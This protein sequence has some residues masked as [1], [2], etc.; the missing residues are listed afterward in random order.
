MNGENDDGERYRCGGK[1]RKERKK[2]ERKRE[3]KGANV[4]VLVVSLFFLEI[5]KKN[6]PVCPKMKLSGRKMAPKGPERTESMVPGSVL[7]CFG[8][9]FF[10]FVVVEVRE[11]KT[12][13]R[14]R[15]LD[16]V[17]CGVFFPSSSSSF[18]NRCFFSFSLR[19]RR[20]LFSLLSASSNDGERR[21]STKRSPWCG[22]R[23]AKEQLRHVT[24][25]AK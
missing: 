8:F 1:E 5:K 6:S 4:V 23:K 20:S 12:R 11:K 7:F 9:C 14:R 17:C 3:K 24:A 25:N 10:G 19:F 22:E 21:N 13:R 16:V 15:K 2:A 18:F